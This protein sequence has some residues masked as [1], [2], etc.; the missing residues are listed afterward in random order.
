MQLI[1]IS[2]CGGVI[3]FSLHIIEAKKRIKDDIVIYG[4]YIGELKI[5]PNLYL[6]EK[7]NPNIKYKVKGIESLSFIDRTKLYMNPWIVID[8]NGLSIDSFVGKTLESII[9]DIS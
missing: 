3:I 5:E 9:L 4:I 2:L 7:Q 1:K 6:I 8:S